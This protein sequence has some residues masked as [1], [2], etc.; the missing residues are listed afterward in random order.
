MAKRG[1]SFGT[2]RTTDIGTD[3]GLKPVKN[4]FGGSSP[5]SLYTVSRESCWARWRRGFELATASLYH[6]SFDYPFTYKIP[7]PTGVPGASGN[8]PA[9]PGIFRGFPTKNKE[10]GVH[11]AGVRVAGSLRF[12]NVVDNSNVRASIASVTEDT[13]YWYVQLA[14][15]WSTANPLPAPLYIP[16]AGTDGIKPTNGEVIEDRIIEIEGAPITRATINPNTQTRYGYVQAVLAD[17]NPSTGLL[18]LRKRGSV[19]ATPD[20]ILVTPATRPPNIGRYFMTGTRYYCTCQDFTRR[21]YAYISSLGQRK[22]NYFPHTRCATLKPGRYEVMKIAGKVANQAMTNAV[23]NRRLEVI[24]PAV[25]YEIPP[26]ISATSSTKIGATR[27]N[28]GVFSDFGGV[29]I[30]S[31]SDPSLP[32]ARSEGL[33]DFEDYAAKDNVITSLTDRWTPTLD[34]FRYCKH[35]YSMKYEEG[36]FPPE[37]SDLPIG[38]RDITAWEQKLVDQVEKDQQGAAE[39]INRYGLSYMDIPPFNC[40]SP[41]MVSMMQKLFNIPSTFVILQNFTMYDKTGKAYTPAQGE[42]PET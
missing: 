30:R 1:S 38:I 10:L 27:D 22:G 35:I 11:W 24:A 14:G 32:G 26:T 23:T 25:E 28:P 41:M 20:Q 37:P 34:E 42:T 7:L 33:P 6:N 8:Q 3:F 2:F 40:Q 39:K 13:E 17:V 29:Y 9:I 12:D 5:E 21:Q 18:T 16:I 15:T 19:E 36:V 4:E 31:G